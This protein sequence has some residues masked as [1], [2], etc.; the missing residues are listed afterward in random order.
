MKP[1][2]NEIEIV[3]KAIESGPNLLFLGQHYL[4]F[5]ETNE[6]LAKLS[7]RYPG[8]NCEF[9]SLNGY[10]NKVIDENEIDWI[11][12]QSSECLVPEQLDTLSKIKWSHIFA[13]AIDDVFLRS[14]EKEWRTINRNFSNTLSLESIR[15]TRNLNCTFLYGNVQTRM[16]EGLIPKSRIDIARRENVVSSILSRLPDILTPLGTLFITGYDPRVDWLKPD[17]LFPIIDSLNPKQVLIFG[18]SDY[19]INDSLYSFLV[20]QKKIVLIEAE[21]A[22]IVD[23]LIDDGYIDVQKNL[24][25]GGRSLRVISNNGSSQIINVPNDLTKFEVGGT[26][27]LTEAELSGNL[28]YSKDKVY[29][30]YREFLS[31]TNIDWNH[32]NL[33][34]NFKRNYETELHISIIA[35]INKGDKGLSNTPFILHGQSGAGKSICLASIAFKIA[36][37]GICPVIYIKHGLYPD[38]PEVDRFIDWAEAQGSKATLI[39]WDGMLSPEEYN[40]ANNRLHDRGRS[41][42]LVGSSYEVETDNI[43]LSKNHYYHADANLDSSEKKRFLEYLDKFSPELAQTFNSRD[44]IFDSYFLASL[45]RLLPASRYRIGKGLLGELDKSLKD[46]LDNVENGQKKKPKEKEFNSIGY[47]FENI[48]IKEFKVNE[49][50]NENL[51]KDLTLSSLLSGDLKNSAGWQDLITLVY[52]VGQFGLHV[53]IDILFRAIGQQNICDELRYSLDISLLKWYEFEDGQIFVGPRHSL[54]AKIVLQKLHGSE[55]NSIPVEAK[56]FERLIKASNVLSYSSSENDSSSQK[57]L[58]DLVNKIGPNQT[59]STFTRNRYLS[60]FDDFSKAFRFLRDNCGIFDPSLVAYEANFLRESTNQDFILEEEKVLRLRNALEVIKKIKIQDLPSNFKNKIINEKAVI[61]G[62]LMESSSISEDEKMLLLGDIDKNL[63]I[64]SSIQISAYTAVISAKYLEANYENDPALLAK[65]LNLFDRCEQQGTED[66]T[67]YF[68]TAYLRILKKAGS[69]AKVNETIE[70]LNSDGS[71]NGH[72]IKARSMFDEYPRSEIEV[73]ESKEKI[74]NALNYLFEN[75]NQIKGSSKCCALLFDLWWWTEFRF[76][77]FKKEKVLAKLKEKDWQVILTISKRILKDEDNNYK[78]KYIFGV[79]L[80]QAGLLAEPFNVS[81]INQSLGLF[82]EMSLERDLNFSGGRVVKYF[83]ASDN[84]GKPICF[85]GIIENVWES[86][87]RTKG[88]VRVFNLQV[89][90]SFLSSDFGKAKHA[91]GENIHNFVLG[92]SMAGVFAL[93]LHSVEP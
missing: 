2:N 81:N 42:V 74:E 84:K 72:Y 1:D 79:S 40:N 35:N 21:L 27:L 70:K 48:P 34:F 55:K 64:A 43:S 16:T 39:V 89:M 20:D 53:P 17:H 36:M 31:S 80:F 91:K 12:R 92:F 45:Y 25:S 76:P 50:N 32:F 28:N 59:G 8:K 47:A 30:E 6:F 66:R 60:H 88:Q 77:L 75:F 15:D 13:S 18:D 44:F 29:N 63:D 24:L 86:N 69:H 58:K 5:K 78:W 46:F 41:V 68:T 38:I 54:D 83:I 93:P 56:C 52:S 26:R 11:E 67:N 23:H 51:N 3:L 33:E 62:Y 19:Y 7:N 14:F 71:C 4:G 85:S 90:V 61:L 37:K 10:V 87:R 65:I 82:K 73:N 9:D 49:T 22:D 57:F